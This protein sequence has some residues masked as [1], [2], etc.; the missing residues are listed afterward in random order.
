MRSLERL[1]GADDLAE[2]ERLP[3][4]LWRSKV[5]VHESPQRCSLGL[6]RLAC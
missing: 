1:W 2:E 4:A 3:Q 6:N 5:R